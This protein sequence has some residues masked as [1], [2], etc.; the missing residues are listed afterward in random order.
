M[1]KS[2]W[3][4]ATKKNKRGGPADESLWAGKSLLGGSRAGFPKP[5]HSHV[6]AE[7]SRAA[8]VPRRSG[9]EP[10]LGEQQETRTERG[11]QSLEASGTAPHTTE[12]GCDDTLALQRLPGGDQKLLYHLKCLWVPHL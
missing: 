1:P 3:A 12:K 7:Q 2:R 4:V 10:V 11:W 9:A 6:P 5:P 8:V